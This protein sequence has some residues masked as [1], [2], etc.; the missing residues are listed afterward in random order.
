MTFERMRRHDVPARCSRPAHCRNACRS[1]G[2]ARCAVMRAAMDWRMPTCFLPHALDQDLLL[3]HSLRDG[4]PSGHL[5]NSLSDTVDSLDLRAFFI[6]YGSGG[7]RNQPFRPAMMVKVLV[8][9]CATGVF[10]S[11]KIASKL[12]EP[13]PSRR[14]KSNAP[15]ARRCPKRKTT[16]PIPA[17]ASRRP[18]GSAALSRAEIDLPRRLLGAYRMS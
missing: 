17:A 5:V 18:G 6:R 2:K 16:S 9:G 14:Q 10:S 7:P 12:H 4:L 13:L 8:D 11:R 15:L 1:E 3:P